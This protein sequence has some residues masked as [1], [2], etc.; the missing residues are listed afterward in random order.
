MSRHIG[1]FEI[2]EEL[3]RGG[4][5]VVYK[6]R[7]ESLQRFVAIKMLGHP[8]VDNDSVVQ[9]FMREARAVADLNHPN[10]VQVFRVDKHEQQPYFAM[11]YVEG[12]SLKTLIQRERRM[13]PTRA[14][15]ILKE[16]AMG[17]AAAH[18]KGVVHRDIKPENIMLTKYGGVKV[19]DFGIARVDEPG[20][21][22]TTTGVG[23]GTPSY[24]SPEVCM[25]QDVDQRS[26]IFSLGV[27][28]FEMLT[29]ETPFKSDSPFELMTKVVE[30]KVPDI[31]TLNPNVDEGIRKILAKMIAKRPKLR[32]QKCDEL[33]SDIEDYRAGRMPRYAR[34][35]LLETVPAVDGGLADATSAVDAAHA[36]EAEADEAAADARTTPMPAAGADADAARSPAANTEAVPQRKN[37]SSGRRWAAVALVVMLLAGGAVA[38]GWYLTGGGERPWT[39]W[40]GDDGDERVIAS[41]DF[42]KRE[43]T[44]AADDAASS[45]SDATGSMVRA[46]PAAAS[47]TGTGPEKAV[48]AS[49][50]RPGSGAGIEPVSDTAASDPGAGG[51]SLNETESPGPNAEA[52]DVEP[53]IGLAAENPGG[54]P[55]DEALPPGS[56][57]ERSGD[58]AATESATRTPE[59]REFS[60]VP[61]I[62]TTGESSGN[63]DAPAAMVA[64]PASGPS[65]MPDAPRVAVI[66]IGDPAVARPVARV[67]K[68]G[69]T[70]ADFETVDEQLM[71]GLVY[72]ESLAGVV[73]TARDNGADVLVYIDVVPTGEREL[74]YFGRAEVQ[75]LAELEVRVVDL[76][77]QRNLG[78]PV[79]RALEY[80]SLT[81]DREARRAAAPVAR[82]VVNRLRALRAMRSGAEPG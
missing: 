35:A 79:T 24:L 44:A 81:A 41:A 70:R 14:L 53:S 6:A 10:L 26:D 69:L 77:K 54:R 64:P 18:E 27:V 9:R 13:Q 63:P 8:L 37:G 23:L 61:R 32:Y 60:D 73:R 39:A 52:E 36:G 45:P 48:D 33:I 49:S 80:V 16:V 1:P 28:L 40:F 11:E 42:G 43:R 17:L 68:R 12:E 30:A 3:G 72:A 65:A 50:T 5:G 56:G 22:L 51:S 76:H 74:Q 59:T 2:V 7:E 82:N 34:N 25:S 47:A 57:D 4:M 78:R 67:F 29:G 55:M 19:V 38:G 71:D 58:P 66:T 46:E 31:K 75:L 62:A 21:R 20:T 15:Q